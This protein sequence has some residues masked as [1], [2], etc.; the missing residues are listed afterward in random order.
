MVVE[1]FMKEYQKITFSSSLTND[2]KKGEL[3]SLK[4]ILKSKTP[5]SFPISFKRI[6][7]I[8]TFRN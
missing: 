6:V 8:F 3:N 2:L 7:I 4:E 1:G 5:E